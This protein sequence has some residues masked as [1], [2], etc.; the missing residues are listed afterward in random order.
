[1]TKACLVFSAV[2]FLLLNMKT[3]AD[4]FDD[5]IAGA[6]ASERKDLELTQERIEILERAIAEKKRALATYEKKRLELGGS[7]NQANLELQNAKAAQV[8]AGKKVQKIAGQKSGFPGFRKPNIDTAALTEAND[9]LQTA[10]TAVGAAQKTFDKFDTDWKAADASAKAAAAEIDAHKRKQGTEKV[11]AVAAAKRQ[12]QKEAAMKLDIDNL[13]L[14]IAKAGAGTKMKDLKSKFDDAKLN[15]KVLEV[16]YNAGL[17]GD[18]MKT[19]LQGLLTD[20]NFCQAVQSCPTGSGNPGDNFEP[21]LDHLFSTTSSE[22][23]KK[24]DSPS[25]HQN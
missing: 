6:S 11:T 17:V 21:N 19:V 7:W 2:L 15:Q 12:Q 20:K 8:K 13:G 14:E 23:E 24:G 9:A 25:S 18:Y 16:T 3:M 1:M 22:R 5:A 10:E 4:S